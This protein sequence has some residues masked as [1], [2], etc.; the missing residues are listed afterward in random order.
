[1]SF[2]FTEFLLAA[3][4]PS[5]QPSRFPR[6]FLWPPEL[7]DDGKVQFPAIDPPITIDEIIEAPEVTWNTHCHN[8]VITIN[9]SIEA[10][11]NWFQ[12]NHMG[13]FQTN[14]FVPYVRRGTKKTASY[15]LDGWWRG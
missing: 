2:D 6:R 15:T 4:E 13:L 1:M 10:G 8:V 5:R 14:T 7:R 11:R 12:I 3:R 9:Q